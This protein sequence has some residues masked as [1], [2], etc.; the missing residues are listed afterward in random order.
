MINEV[1]KNWITPLTTKARVLAYVQERPLLVDE[2]KSD[3]ACYL[4]SCV[5]LFLFLSLFTVRPKSLVFTYRD[6]L[7]H[8]S[9]VEH[10]VVD[11]QDD[12]VKQSAVQRLGHGVARC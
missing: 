9:S 6:R 11:V 2:H 4:E 3:E 7:L 5:C 12:P 10:G 1:L 8:V